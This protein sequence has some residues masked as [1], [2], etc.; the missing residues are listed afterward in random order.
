MARITFSNGTVVNFNGTPTQADIEEISSSFQTPEQPTQPE[1][2][3]PYNATFRAIGTETPAQAGLKATGNLPTSAYNFGK[4]IVKAVANPIDTTLA[5]GNA[6]RGVGQK[7]INTVIGGAFGKDAIGV[8]E[9]SGTQSVDAI[10]KTYKDRYGSLDNALKTAIEDPF[11]VGADLLT[12]IQGGAAVAGKTAQVNNVLSK[13][14]QVATKPITAPIAGASKIVIGG[15]KFAASQATGLSPETIGTIVKNPK[16]F[17]EAQAQ[18][19]T[20]TDL[21]DNVFG[22]INKANDELSD[23]GT[24]YNTVRESGATVSLPDNWIQSSLADFKFNVKN[25]IV[26]AD[27]TSKTRNVTDINKIQGFIDNWGDSKTFTADE[28]LN[29]R[30][31]LAELAKYDQ[32][33]STVAR[34]FATRVREGVLNEDKVRNQIPGLKELDS[35]Y[36]SDIKFYKQMKKDFLT[37]D[38]NLKDGAASKVV[39]SVNAANPERLARL[40]KLYPGFTSQAKVVKALE[41]AENSMGLKVGTYARAGVGLTGLATG[42]LPLIL[43]AVLATPEVVIPLLK[44]LGYT[45]NTIGPILGVVKDFSSDI[46]NFRIPGAVEQYLKEKYPDGVP[47]GMS[48]KSTITPEKIAKKIDL[49]QYRIINEYLLNPADK[50]YFPKAQNLME[51]IGIDK[52]DD[53]TQMSFLQEVKNEYDALNK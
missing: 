40:E 41:D 28:Y 13:T 8:K 49:E 18:G 50:K 37:P 30:H 1:T 23:L 15:T 2:P 11:G 27:R 9:N 43:G 39:N 51:D 44:G 17:G 47:V 16:A 26:T 19:V 5:V 36:S 32:T 34:D 21:A 48:I 35:Q 7:A 4:N 45:K 33:G 38:G 29:M 24:G 22:A 42:N 46:N 52:A 14:A 10:L 20:R 25:N 31:D 12:V 53:A 6:V 3:N